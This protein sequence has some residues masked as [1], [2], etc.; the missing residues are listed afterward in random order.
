MLRDFPEISGLTVRGKGCASGPLK[1]EFGSEN[2]I[3]D[4]V[5]ELYKYDIEAC[6]GEVIATADGQPIFVKHPY[7]KGYV[8]TLL[9]PLEKMLSEKPGVFSDCS[10][11]EYSKIYREVV[12]NCDINKYVDTDSRFIRTTEHIIDESNRYIVAINFSDESQKCKLILKD[13]WEVSEK[14]YNS[15][16]LNELEL[17][18][19]DAAIFKISKSK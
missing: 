10:L 2:I 13:G 7:G 15:F 9:Y 18:C 6:E 14:Y 8:Y 19:N 17:S 12:K 11:P 1:M 3:L 16:D 4:K 5:N